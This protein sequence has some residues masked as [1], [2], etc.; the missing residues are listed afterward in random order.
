MQPVR[1]GLFSRMEEESYALEAAEIVGAWLKRRSQNFFI[2]NRTTIRNH[3]APGD[4]TVVAAILKAFGRRVRREDLLPKTFMP[5]I[6]HNE[7]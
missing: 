4:P 3:R 7:P 2:N 5:T 6:G 1:S